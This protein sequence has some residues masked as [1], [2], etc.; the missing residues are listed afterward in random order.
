MVSPLPRKLLRV[1]WK[2]P[3]GPQNVFWLVLKLVGRPTGGRLGRATVPLGML[4]PRL[5][6]SNPKPYVN[7]FFLASCTLTS[8][9]SVL[10]VVTWA[11]GSTSAQSNTPVRS[12]NLLPAERRSVSVSGF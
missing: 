5:I 7:S 10:C 9:S 6:T 12:Y 8:T 2:V 3:R 4:P 1:Y 11:L